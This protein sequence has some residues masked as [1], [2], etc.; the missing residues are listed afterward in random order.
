MELT[1][2]MRHAITKV[3]TSHFTG[4]SKEDV[5]K[6]VDAAIFYAEEYGPASQTR[7]GSSRCA[8]LKRR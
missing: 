2:Q 4:R 1:T 8:D 5:D 7:T 6:L 3:V